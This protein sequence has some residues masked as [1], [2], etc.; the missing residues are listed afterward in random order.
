MHKRLILIIFK[1]LLVIYIQ[2]KQLYSIQMITL[3]FLL[4]QNMMEYLFGNF[5]EILKQI[6]P[7]LTW[8]V[9]IFQIELRQQLIDKINKLKEISDD[10]EKNMGKFNNSTKTNVS[11]PQSVVLQSIA[12]EISNKMLLI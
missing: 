2:Y 3:K 9:K 6:T 4:C 5:L 11:V 10:P 1:V 8:P 7:Q 12:V